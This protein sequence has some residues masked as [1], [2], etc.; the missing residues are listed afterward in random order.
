MGRRLLICFQV[1]FSF[2][3]RAYCNLLFVLLHH[4][5][6]TTTNH[7]L[8]ILRRTYDHLS[9]NGC[10]NVKCRILNTREIRTKWQSI[11]NKTQW[12]QTAC[13]PYPLHSVKFTS[14]KMCVGLEPKSCIKKY[15]TLR[16]DRD[17]A[18]LEMYSRDFCS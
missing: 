5:S 2:Q 16:E 8:S 15:T 9:P 6:V 14:R 7:L 13:L 11:K 10:N 4:H 17:Y 1:I 18:Y 12:N 3:R